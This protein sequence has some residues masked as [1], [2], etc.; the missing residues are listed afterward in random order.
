MKIKAIREQD[1]HPAYELTIRHNLEDYILD[2]WPPTE[3]I[4]ESDCEM[5]V[6]FKDGRYPIGEIDIYHMDE[7]AYIYKV[8]THNLYGESFPIEFRE[9]MKSMIR[10]I[11]KIRGLR[12]IRYNDC[13]HSH[14]SVET[15]RAE[16]LKTTLINECGFKECSKTLLELKLK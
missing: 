14:S 10:T 11:S 6:A 8:L 5:I 4:D 2:G 1:I 12:G 7:W 13:D 15:E 16:I 9:S 3:T